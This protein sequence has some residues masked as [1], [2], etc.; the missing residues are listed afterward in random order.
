MQNELDLNESSTKNNAIRIIVSALAI[1][2]G[3][4]GFEHGFFEILQGN[5]A[6]EGFVISA[7]GPNQRF[8]SLGQEPAFTIIPNFFITGIL[9][10]INGVSIIIW[11]IFFIDKRFGARIQ[12][13]L[14][15]SLFLV[16][17]GFAPIPPA[18][19]AS[20]LAIEIDKPLTWWQAN[21]PEKI[22]QAFR[23][24]WPWDVILFILLYII[25]IWIAIFGVPLIWFFTEEVT[26]QINMNL[27]LLCVFFILISII[28]AI[29]VEIQRKSA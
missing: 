14:S 13:L 6:P 9:A 26:V 24:L 28:S 22:Q 5:V 11:A 15:I 25:P 8:W 18:L 2:S 16:G 10:M 20:I 12:F 1:L 23:L 7:I 17:G 27:G 29:S 19:L 21:L 4:A 3:F